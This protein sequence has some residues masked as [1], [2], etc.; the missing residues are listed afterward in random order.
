MAS[1]CG[2]TNVIILHIQLELLKNLV[3]NIYA[4]VN[5][6]LRQYFSILN[7]TNLNSELLVMT[8][9]NIASCWL[10]FIARDDSFLHKQCSNLFSQRNMYTKSVSSI[11]NHLAVYWRQTSKLFSLIYI[12]ISPN[13]IMFNMTFYT[14]YVQ[15]DN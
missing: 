15:F 12:N 8:C 4:M 5:Y 7:W 14:N 3:G 10:L 2:L 9:S 1:L 13:S 6:Y 11:S